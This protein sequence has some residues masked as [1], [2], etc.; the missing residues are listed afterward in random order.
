MADFPE[1]YEHGEIEQK[2]A[3]R[4][5]S[6]RVYDW[7]PSVSRE[8]TFI[9]DTP[10]PTVSGSLHVGH[11]FS[12][13]HTDVITRYQRMLGKNIMY[14]MGWDD[15]GLP[16]ERRVQNKFNITCNPELPYQS[17]WLPK[18]AP[19]KSDKA[20]QEEI[21]RKNFIEAC[22]KV[23][24]EDEAAF[25]TLWR[26]L[27]LSVDWKQQYATIDTHCRRV[28][29]LSFLDLVKKDMVYN[30]ESPTMWDITFQTALA[31][32][33]LEERPC[34][35]AYHDLRFSV[36]GG[37]EF[38]ISTTRPELLVACIA[39]VAHPDDERYKSYFGKR[40]L[41]PL[42][43]AEVPVV[44]STHADPEK[45]S[46][47]MMVCT[48]GDVA[49]VEW[50]KSSG[51]PIKQVLGRNGRFQPIEFTNAPFLSTDPAKAN[52]AYAQILGKT[53]QQAR[54][55][56]AQLLAAEGS[57]A[58]GQGAAL[59][60]EPKP[61]EHPVKFYEK[62]D[63]PVEYITTRQ[64]FVR[65]L[66]HK[67][68]LLAQGDKI[69]W[70]PA[71]MKTRY[72]HWV[73]GLNHDWC[74][75]RQRFFGVPFP[76]W[77][78]I[79]AS[80]RVVYER[81]IYAEPGQ[82]PVD[83]FI[84]T[85]KGFDESQR[86]QPGGFTGDRDVMDTWATSSL[87]PQIIS[88][89]G[90]DASRHSKLFPMDIRP[91]SHE[92]IRTWAFY[93]IAKAWMHENEIPWR[94][95]VISGWILDPD[96]KKMSKSKGN[97]VT[98]QHLLEQYSSDAVRYWAA[99]ARLGVDTAFDE[100]VF[101]NGRKLATKLFNASRFVLAIVREFEAAGG[102]AGLD[103]VREELDRAVID[104]LRGV[105]REATT[106]FEAFDYAAALQAAETFFW[107][108]CDNYV[109]LVK[110]RAYDADAGQGRV[111]AIAALSWS[112]KT[113]LRLF[114]P[115][116]PYV[117]DEVWSWSYREHEGDI[118]IHR[119][120]WPTVD[121]V[122]NV[123]RPEQTGV[124]RAAGEVLGK[125]HHQKSLAKKTLKWPV[126]RLELRGPAE[127][128]SRAKAALADVERAGKVVTGGTVLAEGPAGESGELTVT[129][130]LSETMEA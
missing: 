24:A 76:V 127:S 60:G 102:V 45:G 118:S 108:F 20:P 4:W 92:I 105:I 84:D 35:G 107:Q 130:E 21:S 40:A 55:I 49:D 17:G 18:E 93:T 30:A 83:P 57:V 101:A 123:P 124:F 41:T 99:R 103:Q 7:D 79:D 54:K 12:Y 121:E 96:R 16:T 75:S 100:K 2:W 38:V 69:A 111:S 10:P 80:G 19:E 66:E 110:S 95:V 89:W 36:V 3:S 94:N 28:S 117:T 8:R 33:D 13:T 27:G 15:N 58:V 65:L 90:L 26:R 43:R 34:R 78:P 113:F 114:A 104:E 62:G 129:L 53:S 14:P 120:A 61:I 22:A 77:Y 91:Q 39:V 88:Q 87:T 85:P 97:V 44:A 126:Q 116:L 115:V 47:I 71:H 52:E 50:W 59:V 73:A 125:I 70:H 5:E 31:Q 48:F 119:V 112:L 42:F 86:N 51:L 25:E 72:S 1:K 98:P 81:P 68:A 106:A 64:W 128:L 56:I 37:G 63:N 82:L 46:G 23:T 29:Q 9:V 67:E 74:I 122:R 109:E 32:A 6:E 11:V